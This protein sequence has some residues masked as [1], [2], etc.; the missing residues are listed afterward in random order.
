MG[1]AYLHEQMELLNFYCVEN[2][3]TK[4]DQTDDF[5]QYCALRDDPKKAFYLY[6]GCTR[7]WLN[8]KDEQRDGA[9]IGV[10]WPV[11]SNKTYQ[12]ALAAA[13]NGESPN[14]ISPILKYSLQNGATILWMGDLETDFM[15]GLGSIPVVAADIL[16][17]PHHGRDTGKVPAE[18]LAVIKPKL[19]I[20][21]EAPSEDLNY[22]PGYNTIT[23]NSAGDITL[24]CESEKT[25]IYVSEADYCADFLDDEGLNDTY[26]SYIG[27]LKM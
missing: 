11:T 26:G 21:G 20:I 5:D 19:I 16:F 22:Y 4:E 17:A 12:E 3:A 9:G 2:K 24:E 1:L 27:T 14:N 13:E 7:K 15:E 8:E 10:L 6:K 18:W 23:Q 25:H